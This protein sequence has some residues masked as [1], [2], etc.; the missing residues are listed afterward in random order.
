MQWAGSETQWKRKCG[1]ARDDAEAEA[2]IAQAR[3]DRG[4]GDIPRV[5]GSEDRPEGREHSKE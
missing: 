3:R 2:T 5:V 4:E 1:G